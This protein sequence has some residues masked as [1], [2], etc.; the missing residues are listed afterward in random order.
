MTQALL[1]HASQ[2]CAIENGQSGGWRWENGEFKKEESLKS[3]LLKLATEEFCAQKYH[4]HGMLMYHVYLC[5][6][7]YIE[8]AI[9]LIMHSIDH[10]LTRWQLSLAMRHGLALYNAWV[11]S[12]KA[13]HTS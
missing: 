12:Y 10:Q 13:W 6:S 4:V 7:T 3:I 8:Y 9:V 2:S 5:C 1:L 11:S